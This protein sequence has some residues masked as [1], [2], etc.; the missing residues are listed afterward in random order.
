[1]PYWNG[2]TWE[3]VVSYTL[4]P[5]FTQLS[6][7]GDMYR[8]VVATTL[9]NL[10]DINCRF[11]DA[12]GITLNILDCDTPLSSSFLSFSGK[13]VYNHSFLEWSTTGENEAVTYNIEK[14]N[15]ASIFETI[16]S[17]PGRGSQASASNNYS[18][19]DPVTITATAFY[20]LRI[21]NAAGNTKFSNT[22][23][24]HHNDQAGLSF[25]SVTNPFDRE[26]SFQVSSSESGI[27]HIMLM[28]QTG[29]IVAE[30]KKEISNS[31]SRISLY[32]TESLPVGA[33]Y[34]RLFMNGKSIQKKLIRYK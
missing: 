27:L 21:V 8:V 5:A 6:N 7:S 11:T 33:Y 3:Y 9:S 17:V 24:L 30:Q 20:R 10:T 15:N 22:V 18:F 31:L 25:V 12:G 32:R 34:L 28:D 29:R 2:T 14:S 1:M 26:I 13:K 16:G 4:L 19:T 23:V